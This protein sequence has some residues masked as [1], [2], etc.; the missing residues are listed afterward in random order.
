MAIEYMP[1]GD[2]FIPNITIPE[3]D[4]QPIG[5]YG[6]MRMTYLKEHRPGLYTRMLLSGKLMQH[7][8]EIDQTAHERMERI[9]PLMAAQAGIT[10]QLKAE[11][12]LEWVRQMNCIHNCAEEMVL[13][14]LV[15]S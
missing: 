8:H 12:Q 10:E 15:Y 5:K 9:I 6:R 2:Y 11:M 14:E 4:R 13:S 1:C 3:E 7:L